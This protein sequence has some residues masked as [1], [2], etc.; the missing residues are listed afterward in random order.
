MYLVESSRQIPQVISVFRVMLHV[1][2]DYYINSNDSW[3][4]YPYLDGK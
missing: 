1:E 2:I 4:Y 3:Y